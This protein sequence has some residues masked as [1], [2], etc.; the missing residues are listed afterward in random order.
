MHN[1]LPPNPVVFCLSE[2]R[3]TLWTA[4]W[5]KAQ[6]NTCTILCDSNPDSNSCDDV[7]DLPCD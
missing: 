2:P 5:C 1:L 4:S 7:S 3:L 6:E